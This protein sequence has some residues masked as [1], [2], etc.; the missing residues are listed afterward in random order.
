MRNVEEIK[1]L[2]GELGRYKKMVA[3]RDKQIEKLNGYN[4]AVEEL[5]KALDSYMIQMCLR[6]GFT[7]E[8]GAELYEH[9]LTLPKNNIQE[10]LDKYKLELYAGE[11]EDEIIMRAVERESRTD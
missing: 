2:E 4:E 9:C 6:F 7:E 1:R 5:R 11:N 3:D 10:T 8:V